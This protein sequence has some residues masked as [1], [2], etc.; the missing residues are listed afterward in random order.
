MA[1]QNI[2]AMSNYLKMIRA[3]TQSYPAKMI[4]SKSGWNIIN[5]SYIR[6]TVCTLLT[7]LPWSGYVS[8]HSIPGTISSATPNPTFSRSN[9]LRPK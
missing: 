2:Y 4:Y 7:E 6:N 9:N 5:T 1:A 3:N 8:P